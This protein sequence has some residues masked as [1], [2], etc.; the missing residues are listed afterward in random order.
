[1]P[2]TYVDAGVDQT[3][4]DK[5]IDRLLRLMKRTHDPGVIDLPWG[6]A[7]LYALK[8]S[9]LFARNYRDPVLVACT[10]GVGTKLKVARL[11]NRHDTVGI[12]LVAM[13]VNDLVVTGATPLFFLDY[14][15]MGKYDDALFTQLGEGVVKGCEL[16]PC[17]LLGGETA[18]MPGMYADGE[19]D[20]AGFAVGIVERSR[21]IDGSAV[22]A[23]DDIIGLASTGLHSNGYSLARKILF[24]A[25]H[26]D[27]REHVPDLGG[28]LGETLLKPTRIYAPAVREVLRRYKVKKAVRAIANITGGGLIENLP[29]VLPKGCAA[30]MQEGA[31]RLPPIFPY[32]QNLGEVPR[33]EMYRVFNMG[34][35]MA[36]VVA[37][38][39]TRPILRTLARVGEDAAIIGKIVKGAQEVRI[40][41]RQ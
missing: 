25:R 30:E 37:P 35:G 9:G 1:M 18:E 11:M 29:R 14:I 8:S 40:L 27:V 32:L 5:G 4:K 3:R 28:P 15:A 23:G 38:H 16:T 41:P 26:K 20:M 31:W 2:I 34:V 12:D 33:E 19:V 10:D 39:F 17:A 21:I 36:L 24:D 22:R 7:G 13:S 6:F